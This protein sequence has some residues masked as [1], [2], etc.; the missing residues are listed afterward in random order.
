LEKGFI[1]QEDK[2][3]E[4]GN[5]MNRPHPAEILRGSMSPVLEN[6]IRPC[7]AECLNSN[8]LVN[9]VLTPSKRL[10]QLLAAVYVDLINLI[11]SMPLTNETT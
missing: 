1:Y 4:P 5:E 9:A 6:S 2:L 11:L 3:C 10:Q 7:N 8:L